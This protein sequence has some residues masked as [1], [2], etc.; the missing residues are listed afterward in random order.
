MKFL[1]LENISTRHQ[2]NTGHFGGCWILLFLLA[3]LVCSSLYPIHLFYFICQ[4]MEALGEILNP[5]ALVATGQIC[6]SFPGGKYQV[7]HIYN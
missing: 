4:E 2:A 7:S 5:P 6:V 1:T 3:I